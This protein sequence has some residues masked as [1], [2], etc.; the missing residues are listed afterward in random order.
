MSCRTNP[1]EGQVR[2]PIAD[3]VN[4]DK[5]LLSSGRH[6]EAV[7]GLTGVQS[8][9]AEQ[10]AP[11]AEH[12]PAVSVRKSLA[13][14]DHIISL[15]DGKPY[16]TLRRHLSKHGLTPDDYRQRYGLKPDYPMVAPAYAETRRE[17]ATKIGLG[18]KR[19]QEDGGEQAPQ[20]QGGAEQAPSPKPRRGRRPKAS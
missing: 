7:T 13:S 12:V 11:E 8:S 10:E 5:H 9:V 17:L 16:K 14:K 2:S 19:K 3:F 1:A 15:I 20:E 6:P 4:Q 18:R